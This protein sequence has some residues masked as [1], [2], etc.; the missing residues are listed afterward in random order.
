MY[1][2]SPF[3]NAFL[4]GMAQARD[5]QA[6]GLENA[7]SQMK[8]QYFPQLTENE[9]QKGNLENKYYEKKIHF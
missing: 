6:K 2:S 4:S 1:N 5:V 3:Y 8:N 9:I 7:L